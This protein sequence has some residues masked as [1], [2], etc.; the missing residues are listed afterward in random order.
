M[1]YLWYSD[2]L[3]PGAARPRA[4]GS[5]LPVDSDRAE[6]ALRAP[7]PVRPAQPGL[8]DRPRPLRRLRLRR[9]HPLGRAGTT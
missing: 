5:A 1:I 8:P 3:Q 9:T 7:R 2:P 6:V 4:L